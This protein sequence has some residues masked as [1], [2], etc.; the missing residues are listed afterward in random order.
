MHAVSHV[1]YL[2][3][4]FQSTGAGVYPSMHWAEETTVH[5]RFNSLGFNLLIYYHTIT[6]AHVDGHFLFK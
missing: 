1:F 6:F 4:A 2:L 3:I 5:H